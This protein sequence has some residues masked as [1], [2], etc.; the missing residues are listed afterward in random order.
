MDSGHDAAQLRRARALIDEALRTADDE[1][2]AVIAAKLH[3]VIAYLD[4]RL[5]QH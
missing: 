2:D 3:D 5:T 4:E 1:A